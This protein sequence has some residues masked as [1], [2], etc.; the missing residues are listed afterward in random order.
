MS[1]HPATGTRLTYARVYREN[2]QKNQVTSLLDTITD[3]KTSEEMKE[4]ANTE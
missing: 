4:R 3:G 1:K 2:N